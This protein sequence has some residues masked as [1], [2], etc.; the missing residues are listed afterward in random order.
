[1]QVTCFFYNMTGDSSAELKSCA[2]DER[3]HA[4]I[5]MEDPNLVLDLRTENKGR[6]ANKY[7]EFFDA[8]QKLINEM[9]AEDERRHG[10]AHMSAFLSIR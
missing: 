4:A 9:T 5:A 10:V 6:P 7:D 2:I 8:A 3:V 1:M